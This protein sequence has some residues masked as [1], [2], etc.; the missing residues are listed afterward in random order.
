MYSNLDWTLT[1]DIAERY[2]VTYNNEHH[3]MRK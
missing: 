3:C 1:N 2:A